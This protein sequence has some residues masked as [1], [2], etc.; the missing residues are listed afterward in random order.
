MSPPLLEGDRDVCP[1]LT[2]ERTA[3][4]SLR[5]SIVTLF[6]RWCGVVEEPVDRLTQGET[7]SHRLVRYWRSAGCV[8]AP[9]V[10]DHAISLTPNAAD[11]GPVVAYGGSARIV[12][13]PSFSGF[14]AAYL[15]DPDYVVNPW[16]CLAW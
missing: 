14:I 11:A 8:I 10:S 3:S 2:W 12:L 9:G 15:E 6:E 7:A 13:A 16:A 5:K 4:G 1:D